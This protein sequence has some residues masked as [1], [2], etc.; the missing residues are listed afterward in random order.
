MIFLLLIPRFG[1]QSVGRQGQ[2]HDIRSMCSPLDAQDAV[3]NPDKEVVFFAIGFE[4]TAQIDRGDGGAMRCR[5]LQHL[6]Q[7]RDD[8]AAD[9]GHPGITGPT[10]VDFTKPG[11]SPPSS[12]TWPYRFVPAVSKAPGGGEFEPLDILASIAM[13]LQLGPEGR[14][15]VEN[16]YSRWST[17][18][19]IRPPWH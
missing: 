6:H 14:C 5:S 16:Q 19:A 18:R 9:Q 7:P 17:R 1:W 4:T 2:Q 8:R 12:V 11:A 10:P 13:L 3:D 15:E